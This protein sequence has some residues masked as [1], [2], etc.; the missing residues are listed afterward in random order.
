M[1]F[2]PYGALLYLCATDLFRYKVVLPP[3]LLIWLAK[4]EKKKKQA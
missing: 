3:I 1:A 4:I 2:T